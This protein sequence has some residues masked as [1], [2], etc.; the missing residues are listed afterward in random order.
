MGCET[1][2]FCVFGQR[3]KEIRGDQRAARDS[4]GSNSVRELKLVRSNGPHP[5]TPENSRCMFRFHW[6]R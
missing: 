1:V 4:R 3:G 5:E 2:L 6:I